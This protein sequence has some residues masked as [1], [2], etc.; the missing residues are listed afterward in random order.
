MHVLFCSPGTGRAGEV[1]R[2]GQSIRTVR[3]SSDQSSGPRFDCH[4]V[5]I[6]DLEKIIK[7]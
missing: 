2:K 5:N 1:V 3:L 4:S 6:T 7:F